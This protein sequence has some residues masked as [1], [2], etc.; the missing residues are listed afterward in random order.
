[1]LWR[2]R[3]WRLRNP[4]VLRRTGPIEP[5]QRAI[6]WKVAQ[7]SPPRF[8][9]LLANLLTRQPSYMRKGYHSG[10]RRR[11]AG[12]NALRDF[13]TRT[14]SPFSPLP[15]Q[16]STKSRCAFARVPSQHGAVPQRS[17]PLTPRSFTLPASCM[18][19]AY[20]CVSR[21]APVLLLSASHDPHSR[22]LRRWA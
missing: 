10:R 4:P 15:E 16:L 14:S 1:M 21:V 19:T 9:M 7:H 22:R 13:R 17:L 12:P 20:P 8:P 5:H 18:L 6:R 2:R 11:A 3:P